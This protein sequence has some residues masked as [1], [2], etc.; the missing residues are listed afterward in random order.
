MFFRA[1]FF[2]ALTWNKSVTP[3]STSQ[4]S[5]RFNVFFLNASWFAVRTAQSQ[6]PNAH[7]SHSMECESMLF[8]TSHIPYLWF[9]SKSKIFQQLHGFLQLR[10]CFIKWYEKGLHNGG[11]H[12]TLN[13]LHVS[14]CEKL[15]FMS[16]MKQTKKRKQTPESAQWKSSLSAIPSAIHGFTFR[17]LCRKKKQK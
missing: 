6:H 16:Y 17:C 9:L 10:S 1:T 13:L 4:L 11:W 3:T 7:V 12:E 15:P 14:S 5:T 2:V 8:V